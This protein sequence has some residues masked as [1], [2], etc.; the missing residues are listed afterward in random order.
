MD[1]F[2]AVLAPGLLRFRPIRKEHTVARMTFTSA[3]V[4]T[5]LAASSSV[6]AQPINPAEALNQATQMLAAVP[7]APSAGVE[8]IAMLR[9]DFADFASAYLA[10]PGTPATGT[11]GA[12][13]TSGRGDALGDWRAKYQRVEADLGALLGPVGGAATVTLDPETRARLD[14]VRSQLRMFYAATMSQ[15]DGNPI[16]HTGAPQT[17]ST[18]APAAPRPPVAPTGEAPQ[19]PPV[20]ATPPAG[21]SASPTG[22]ASPSAARRNSQVDTEW[23]TALAMLDRVERILNDATREPGKINIDRAS[24]DEIRAEIGQIRTMLRATIKN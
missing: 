13:G 19:T 12:V 14:G 18:G 11:A 9:T 17:S 2:Y 21:G 10:G 8:Q 22:G 5:A 15:P 1:S 24:I 16:A 6:H 4:L 20:Q 3:I 23:G 7:S